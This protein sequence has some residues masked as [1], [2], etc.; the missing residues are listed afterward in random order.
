MQPHQR[1]TSTAQSPNT[2]DEKRSQNFKSGPLLFDLSTPVLHFHY[3]PFPEHYPQ[4]PRHAPVP[5]LQH[6]VQTRLFL[7]IMWDRSTNYSSRR[8][9]LPN[10]TDV[11]P[12]SPSFSTTSL[13]APFAHQYTRAASLKTRDGPKVCEGS[14]TR[15]AKLSPSTEDSGDCPCVIDTRRKK[16]HT[17]HQIIHHRAC[18]TTRCAN[19]QGECDSTPPRPCPYLSPRDCPA[20]PRDPHVNITTVLSCNPMRSSASIIRP[21]ICIQ[22]RHHRVIRTQIFI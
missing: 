21:H 1:A 8:D 10:R 9:H 2:L 14:L 17:R 19:N 12:Q 20:N 5:V 6:I 15:D 4:S 22:L 18:R 11:L 13:N 7:G 3:S 16:I